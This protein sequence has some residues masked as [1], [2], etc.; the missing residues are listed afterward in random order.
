MLEIWTIMNFNMSNE[1][2]QKPSRGT[3]D[4]LLMSRAIHFLLSYLKQLFC[5]LSEY[6]AHVLLITVMC[7]CVH[8]HMSEARSFLG[9]NGSKENLHGPFSP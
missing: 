3:T 8:I 6:I 9:V 1:L 7:Y 5:I 2:F 4:N